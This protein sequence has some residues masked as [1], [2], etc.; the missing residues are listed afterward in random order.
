MLDDPK[1]STSKAQRHDPRGEDEPLD[2]AV[3]RVRRKLARLMLVSIGTLLI[4]VLAVLGAV[5]YRASGDGSTPPANGQ[6]TIA[7]VPGATVRSSSLAP[8]GLLVEIALPDGATELVVLDPVSGAPRLRVR[9]APGG[10]GEGGP[11]ATE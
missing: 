10:T 11:S 6:G 3:E 5:I 4:G 9:L 1:R 7:L 8:N 2:P